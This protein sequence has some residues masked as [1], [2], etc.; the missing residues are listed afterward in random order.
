MD[1]KKKK[2]NQFLIENTTGEPS[3]QKIHDGQH[4]TWEE[5]EPN[6]ITR[7][8]LEVTF[9][10]IMAI[11]SSLALWF[12]G[13]DGGYLKRSQNEIGLQLRWG[14]PSQIRIFLWEICGGPSCGLI[15]GV[16]SRV[17]PPQSASVNAHMQFGFIPLRLWGL[18]IA[19]CT[20]TQAGGQLHGR[21][22]WA[23]R[24]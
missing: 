18:V 8:L 2:L 1:L 3:H 11:D 7:L 14:V 12:S 5:K 22:S 16:S 23:I 24:Q 13:H 17:V 4:L 6:P 10:F 15:N 19:G 20:S 21:A 9:S